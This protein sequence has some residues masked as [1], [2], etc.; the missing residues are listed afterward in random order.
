MIPQ[1]KTGAILGTP[2]VLAYRVSDQSF[3]LLGPPESA[4]SVRGTD[5]W[6]KCLTV[7]IF[8]RRARLPAPESTLPSSRTSL[9][10]RGGKQTATGIFH[11]LH[12]RCHAL[13][14]FRSRK[15]PGDTSATFLQNFWIFLRAR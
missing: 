1:S 13:R 6:S 2:V 8:P 14:W 9:P 15:F 4:R 3:R 12:F 10:N 11:T 5:R 7:A